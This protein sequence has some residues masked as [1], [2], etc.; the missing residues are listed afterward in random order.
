MDDLTDDERIAEREPLGGLAYVGVVGQIKKSIVHRY[1]FPPQ[2][3]AIREGRRRV[4]IRRPGSRL[5]RVVAVDDAAGTIDLSRGI[6]S[7][8]PHP[9]SL[10]P[11]DL[12]PTKELRSSLMRMGEWVAEHGIDADVGPYRA[13]RDL[14]LRRPPRAG[15]VRG[16]RLQPGGDDPTEVAVRVATA[17]DDSALPIQGP[18]GSGKTYTGAQMVLAL[19]A[20]G[21]K[22]GV[23]ANS[24]KV[25]GHLLD[26]IASAADKDGVSGPDRTEAG[27]GRRSDLR[28]GA[29]LQDERRAAGGPPRRRARRRRRDGLGLVARGL[30][31]NAGRARR[32]R[33][34]PDRARQRPRRLAGRAEPGPAR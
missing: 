17:L 22:V 27:D 15:Q 34:G 8:V 4:A 20:A 21:R 19:V 26:E 23:T 6:T 18:P 14:L 25:I 2:E 31:G 3:H 12:I 9:T 16:A 32:R 29:L 1:R 7:D 13:A 30:R 24:H 33:G 10:V 11:K 28:G 5:A